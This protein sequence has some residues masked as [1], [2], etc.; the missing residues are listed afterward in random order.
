MR[1]FVVECLWLGFFWFLAFSAIFFGFMMGVGY[2]GR[3]IDRERERLTLKPDVAASRP[4][5]SAAR[6]IAAAS[7]PV[8]YA[9]TSTYAPF[10]PL[11]TSTSRARLSGTKIFFPVTVIGPNRSMWQEQRE[12]D[13]IRLVR[14]ATF[15]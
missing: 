8:A 4:V 2:Y 11:T 7:R 5:V 15:Q 10:A 3:K 13:L 1:N 6:P 9:P 14:L 12:L